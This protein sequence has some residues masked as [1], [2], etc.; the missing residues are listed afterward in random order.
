MATTERVLI[1]DNDAAL[2]QS[3]AEQFKRH[4]GFDTIGV[5]TG[6]QALDLLKSHHFAAI[7]MD[8]GLPDT[9]GHDLCRLMRRQGL[10]TPIIMLSA[11]DTDADMI[12]S[13]DSGAN[14]YV[15]KPFRLGVLLARVRAQ[16]R[17]FRL[18]DDAMFPIGPY[19]FYPS[20]KILIETETERKINLTEKETALLK[21]LYRM[22]NRPVPRQALLDQIW[23]YR[24]GVKSHT[25]ETH[26]YRLRQKIEPNP[27]HA[28][29]LVT[30]AEGYRLAR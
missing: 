19:S 9:G 5:E 1:V 8:V 15:A 16:H 21:F 12:L 29:F 27:T 25:I 11:Y 18:S 14:D 17:Q 24:A 13:L 26:I 2:R 30:E 3:L 6:E 20:T 4:E 22:G 7:L 10:K 23:G 28:Q